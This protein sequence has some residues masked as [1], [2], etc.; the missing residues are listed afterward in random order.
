MV[1]MQYGWSHNI[2]VS[3]NTSNIRSRSTFL[4][5]PMY[6]GKS[7][8]CYESGF[9]DTIAKSIRVTRLESMRLNLIDHTEEEF[10]NLLSK[11]PLF[12]LQERF[13]PE[14][15]SYE[16]NGFILFGIPGNKEQTRKVVMDNQK[17]LNIILAFDDP[18]KDFYYILIDTETD[19]GTNEEFLKWREDIREMVVKPIFHKPHVYGFDF[20]CRASTPDH[21]D[22]V[23]YDTLFGKPYDF[24]QAETPRSCQTMSVGEI[25][26]SFFTRF[27]H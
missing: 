26:K 1:Q 17:R 23:D 25:I 4:V 24:M 19:G 21:Y 10:N 2:K 6:E 7:F 3:N 13:G 8:K 11:Q 15:P 20:Y 22:I 16:W 27:R 5:K 9:N 18:D 14:F 12:Y